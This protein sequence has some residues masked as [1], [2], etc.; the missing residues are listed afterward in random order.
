MEQ[1]APEARQ[2]P[3]EEI[4]ILVPGEPVPKSRPRVVGGHAYTPR[5]TME[6]EKQIA[7]AYRAEH[8]NTSFETGVPLRMEVN[9]GLKI[10]TS[11]SKRVKRA[12]ED[13]EV[14]PTGRPDVDNLQKCVQ[15]ALNG[16]AYAD[17]A[18]IVEVVASKRYA[19]YPGAEIVIR[20]IR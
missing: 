18:Q 9:F 1:N 16:V 3:L 12:M 11:K 6:Y 8:G 15:D 7:L 10:P 20:R 17:D 14:R 13:G 4:R 2:S 5:R 19:V